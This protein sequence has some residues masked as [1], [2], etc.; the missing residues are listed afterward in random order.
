MPTQTNVVGKDPEAWGPA[1][2]WTSVLRGAEGEVPGGHLVSSGFRESGG[3][4]S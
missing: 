3:G 2:L 1:K 4:H